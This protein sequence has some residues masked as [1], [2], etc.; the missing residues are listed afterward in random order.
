[1]LLKKL[2]EDGSGRAALD[3]HHRLDARVQVAVAWLKIPIEIEDL[4][5]F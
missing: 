2:D 4:R 1:M 5:R 3:C